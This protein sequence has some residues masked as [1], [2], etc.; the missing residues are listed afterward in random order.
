MRLNNVSAFKSRASA[1]MIRRALQNTCIDKGA[2]KG[3]KLLDQINE[4]AQ[5][6]VITSDIKEWATVT[7][8]IG[9]DAAHPES[10]EVEIEEAESIIALTEQLL[11]V[12][13]ISPAI[14]EERKK[15]RNQ[16]TK[17]L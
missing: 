13:Y 5:K 3:S 9:N 12:I 1:T 6:G 7:R 16:K 17:K 4:L 8:W 14:A 11:N 10:P 2:T 15:I